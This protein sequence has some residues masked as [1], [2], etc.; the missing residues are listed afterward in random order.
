V[1]N[2]LSLILDDSKDLTEQT[3]AHKGGFKQSQNGT[4]LSLKPTPRSKRNRTKEKHKKGRHLQRKIVW[5]VWETRLAK[6]WAFFTCL[7]R[8]AK[9]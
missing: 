9:V 7:E 1:K 3:K 6:G 4:R 8:P 5:L 2:L